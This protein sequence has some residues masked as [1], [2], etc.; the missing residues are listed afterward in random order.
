MEIKREAEAAKKNMEE[1]A[2][3]KRY[4]F[5]RKIADKAGADKIAVGHN[6]ND[7]AETILFRFLRGSGIEGFSAIHPVVAEKIIR[8]LVECPRHIIISYLQSRETCFREDS[9]NS[10]T[11]LARNKIRREL[12]PYLEKNFN[13]KL[14]ATL[15]REAELARETW[16][17]VET[18]ARQAFDMA[19][20]RRDGSIVLDAKEVLSRHPGL[21]KPILRIALKECL[22]S[23]RGIE[24]VHIHNLLSLFH[25]DR[26]G[27]RINLPGAIIA[28][29]Q[30]G[31]I[32]LRKAIDAQESVE[33]SYMLPIPG[34]CFV[35]EARL[36]FSAEIS[37]A[38]DATV[39]REKRST[40]AFIETSAELQRL[41]IRSRALGDRYGGLGHRKVKKMLINSKI[42]RSLRS[43]LPMAA[44]DSTV[45]WVPGFRPAANFEA[46]PGDSSCVVIKRVQ[47]SS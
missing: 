37:V 41:V 19:H 43:N 29:R 42:P 45:I 26:S 28:E 15:A 18:N 2:R 4:E 7:Q 6:L 36:S 1:Y 34:E 40:H 30:F 5:L 38:P 14:I 27:D 35:P 3:L 23:L 12:I 16:S 39:M 47:E 13:P 33:F 22:G 10:D 11:T 24:S 31:E 17:F 8:P 9:S 46:K 32:I 20:Q 25:G 44:I 21:Q